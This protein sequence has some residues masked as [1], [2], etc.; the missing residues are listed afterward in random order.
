MLDEKQLDTLS[1]PTKM[2]RKL[3]LIQQNKN[4]SIENSVSANDDLDKK[5][6]GRSQFETESHET[7]ISGEEE[8]PTDLEIRIYD[9]VLKLSKS[10]VEML[11][12]YHKM[13]KLQWF[14]EIK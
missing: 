8:A 14:I 3:Q 1:L 11:D 2:L 12:K 7:L 13:S 9:N 10:D 4:L 5:G 6:K